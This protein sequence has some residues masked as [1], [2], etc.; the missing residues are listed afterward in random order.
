MGWGLRKS[1]FLTGADSRTWGRELLFGRGCHRRVGKELDSIK[2]WFGKRRV[3]QTF[4]F[5]IPRNDAG[6]EGYGHW[7]IKKMIGMSNLEEEGYQGKER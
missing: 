5:L 4:I 6:G 2:Q 3:E 7:G 1:D